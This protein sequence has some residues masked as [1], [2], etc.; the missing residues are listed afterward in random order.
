VFAV[1]LAGVLAACGGP[2]APQDSAKTHVCVATN[3]DGLAPHTFNQLAA[4][5][6]NSAGAS[7][8]VV[9]SRAP[10]DYLSS[11]QRCVASH[12]NL[13]IA[14]SPDMASA[15]WRSAQL[16]TDQKF[17]LVDATPVDDN[18]QE[19]ALTNVTDLLFNQ[20]EPAYL[21]GALAGLMEK[22]KVGNASHNVL[23][24][25]ASNH[26]SHVDPYI[27]GFVAGARQVDPNVNIKITY[28]DSQD[29]AFCK[30]LGITQISAG[31]DILFEV[32]GRCA[33]GYIDAAYD[34]SSYAIGSDN[35]EAFLSPAVITSAV[36]RVDRAVALTVQRL[37]NGQFKS[38]QQ[39]FSLQDDAT[40]FS[41]PSSVVP[42]D[43]I[44]QVQ[45]LRSMIRSGAIIPPETIPPGV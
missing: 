43:I 2:S 27:A 45:D 41:T 5:G 37:Q 24:I 15:V 16:H 26:G 10:S 12:P 3:A 7:V 25:L 19:V 8:Q 22:E 9:A 35:D 36:K 44:N 11:L 39:V 30:Q 33:S 28:S 31:A 23:G 40:T 32:T 29:T 6:A 17:A 18:G 4:D 1:A 21:V 13:V 34:A 20:Q 42:Q 38:G 14:I